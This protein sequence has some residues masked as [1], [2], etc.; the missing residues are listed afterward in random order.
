MLNF[1]PEN[2]VIYAGLLVAVFALEGCSTVR[3]TQPPETATEQLLISTAV[4]HAVARLNLKITPGTKVFVD[5]QYFRAPLYSQYAIASVRN[6]L[7]QLGARLVNNRKKSNV[8]V[9]LRS[10][11]QSINHHQLLIGVPAIPIPVPLVGIVTT[12]ELALF[13]ENRQVGIAKMAIA[14]YKR[15]GALIAS[16]GAL[17][18]TSHDTH[19]TVLLAF[20]WTTQN[21]MQKAG[22][23]SAAFSRRLPLARS[24]GEVARSHLAVDPGG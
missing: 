23:K 13:E 16:T 10:G 5:A 21:I 8:V 15:N 7:L 2:W 24:D 12:P 1:R 9:E 6:R 19:W 3:T 4:D 20:S 18:G 14:S 22:K 11:A 17:Y